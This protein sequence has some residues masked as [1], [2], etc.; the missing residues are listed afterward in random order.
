MTN[1][2]PLSDG[3]LRALVA[4][5]CDRAPT[6]A[7]ACRKRLLAE[8]E[9]ARPFLADAAAL[10]AHDSEALPRLRGLLSD[11][12]RGAAVDRLARYLEAGGASE[13]EECA[14]LL[15]AVRDPGIERAP[16]RAKLDRWADAVARRVGSQDEPAAIASA[17]R[18]ELAVRARLGG[19]R[20]DY[21][22]PDNS[23]LYR[24]LDSGRGI[25][26]SLSVVWLLVARRAGLPLRG[27]GLP[28]H[29]VVRCG[30]DGGP[31]LDPFHGGRTLARADCNRILARAGLEPD[32]RFL[33]PVQD[34][35]IVARMLRNLVQ[36]YEK[37]RDG[38]RARTFQRLLSAAERGSG[39]DRQP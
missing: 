28:G 12:D 14:F 36:S 20:S 16:Y 11:V 35:A 33:A 25:P 9:R 6:V 18:E 1:P 38:A 37:R 34:D 3:D 22:A 13:L 5:A 19:N 17:L 31:F 10:A 30:T 26:I 24:V 27:I 7:L 15:A 8:G 2:R 21:D 23:F 4:L 39:E 32:P 29:F